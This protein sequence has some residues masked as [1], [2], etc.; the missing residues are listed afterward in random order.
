MSRGTGEGA[1]A[2]FESFLQLLFALT[3][4]L[5]GWPKSWVPSQGWLLPI[6]LAVPPSLAVPRGQRGH[7]WHQGLEE[8]E[9]SCV[10]LVCLLPKL[11][12]PPLYCRACWASLG[13]VWFGFCVSIVS[14]AVQLSLFHGDALLG[15]SP[16]PWAKHNAQG[17]CVP[18]LSVSA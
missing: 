14:R 5:A 17:P 2:I 18:Q 9:G 16:A 3:V 15:N 8:E 7:M 4:P 11:M 12:D 13:V 6:G 1:R 10:K